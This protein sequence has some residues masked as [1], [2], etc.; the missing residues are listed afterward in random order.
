MGANNI[1]KR[2]VIKKIRDDMQNMPEASMKRK[3][4]FRVSSS[5][6]STS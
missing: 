4:C 2:P 1:E 5:I 6:S 3:E